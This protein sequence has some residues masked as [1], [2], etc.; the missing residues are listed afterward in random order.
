MD[1]CLTPAV[2]MTNGNFHRL[3]LKTHCYT[4][5]QLKFGLTLTQYLTMLLSIRWLNGS[6]ESD[7]Q[8]QDRGF[9]SRPNQ[10]IGSSKTIP[11]GPRG[12]NGASV[13]SAVNEYLAIDRNSNC[14]YITCGALKRVSG[15]I[16]PRELSR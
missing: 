4:L 16:L 13:H 11:R 3:V 7:S 6:S 2:G 8:P 10:L 14:T 12:D 5:K 15:C 9:E 1:T